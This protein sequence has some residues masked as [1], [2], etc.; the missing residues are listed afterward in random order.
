MPDTIRD[1]VRQDSELQA[2]LKSLLKEKFL[3]AGIFHPEA[4]LV[5]LEKIERKWKR[6]KKEGN[7]TSMLAV[8]VAI[9][10]QWFAEVYSSAVSGDDPMPSEETRN[11][12]SDWEEFVE[13]NFPDESEELLDAAA[14]IGQYLEF[15]NRR[16][17]G[18]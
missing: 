1:L 4:Y 5:D 17:Q 8:G 9:Y 14:K 15:M 6:R 16:S 13:E 10:N 3:A 12:L 11:W 2:D 7:R 18:F